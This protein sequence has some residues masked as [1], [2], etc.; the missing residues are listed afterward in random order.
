MLLRLSGWI[1]DGLISEARDRLVAE[2]LQSLARTVSLAVVERGV[3]LTDRDADL[4]AGVLTGCGLDA[5]PLSRVPRQATEPVPTWDFAPAPLT[6]LRTGGDR[7]GRCLDLT[8][9][10]DLTISPDLLDD[11]DRTMIDLVAGRP[12][13]LG[14]W[15][16]WRFPPTGSPG[17]R[18]YLIEVTPR[19]D[20]SMLALRAQ[21]ALSDQGEISP[22]IETYASGSPLP[23]YQRTARAW[24][25][26]LWAST[27]PH[28]IH[29]A[30][31]YDTIDP[32]TGPR[33]APDHPLLTDIYLR[34]RLTG[35]LTSATL[36]R[37]NDVLRDD[38]VDPARRATVPWNFR[39]DG[40]WIWSDALAYYLREHGLA[41]TGDFL[42]HLR[43]ASARPPELDSV[44]TFR[45]RATLHRK[46]SPMP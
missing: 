9:D 23:L 3:P 29:R 13:C 16:T 30:P 32:G 5:G 2:D 19:T 41:P 17:R 46:Q 18:V 14:L 22:Q 12:G 27:P 33:F 8:D 25:S 44:T 7:I 1:P 6:A 15:R 45:A 21:V 42:D 38:I 26:L 37:A 28:L 39:T 10:Q 35:Y 31:V 20:P 24:S 43:T 40:A 34:E 36:V 4:L 11:R